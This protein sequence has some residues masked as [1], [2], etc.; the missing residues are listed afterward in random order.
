MLRHPAVIM[1]R[2]GFHGHVCVYTDRMHIVFDP[3][4]RATVNY[5]P[6]ELIGALTNGRNASLD[7]NEFKIG[8]NDLGYTMYRPTHRND[9]GVEIY[10]KKPV[11]ARRSID[12]MIISWRALVRALFRIHPQLRDRFA[13][14][15][16]LA[17]AR[18]REP[19]K[20]AGV[21]TVK[22][23]LRVARQRS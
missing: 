14:E 10:L 7:T 19:I 18:L 23:A 13:M 8:V 2:N 3:G 20:V 4:V 16:I 21:S 12:L 5:D 9:M 1:Q 15:D 17:Q 22:E 6:A 11:E